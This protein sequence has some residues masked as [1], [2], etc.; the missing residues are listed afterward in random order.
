VSHDDDD[1]PKKDDTKTEEIDYTILNTSLAS[2]AGYIA[3]TLQGQPNTERAQ[4]YGAAQRPLGIARLRIVEMVLNIIRLNIH[5][6]SLEL[7]NKGVFK[8][9][10]DLMVQ[11]EWNNMLHNFVEKILVSTL[12]S[13]FHDVRDKVR[14]FLLLRQGKS[15]SI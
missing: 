2:A 12:E 11:Y 8:A 7:A 13:E 4:T 6:V 14:D 15:Y 5:D 1:E 10:M 3:Q 9:L